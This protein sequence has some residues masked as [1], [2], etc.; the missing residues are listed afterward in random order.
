M[1]SIPMTRASSPCGRRSRPISASR[2]RDG[3]GSKRRWSSIPITR[4]GTRPILALPAIARTPTPM[5]PA[6]YGSVAEPQAGVL[7]GLAACRAQLGDADGRGH[8]ARR[9]ARDGAELSRNGL[10]VEQSSL[11]VRGGQRASS[12]RIVE[13][14][15]ERVTGMRTQREAV[16]RAPDH[17]IRSSSRESSRLSMHDCPRYRRA[18]FP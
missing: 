1:R 5:A 9:A 8:G 18:F 2:M 12:R 17:E 11:Q 6:V 10:F 15:P 16:A 4:L 7:A 13:G 14:R 3:G